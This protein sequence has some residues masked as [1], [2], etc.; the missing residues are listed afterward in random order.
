MP[1]HFDCPGSRS[2]TAEYH[3]ELSLI[4]VLNR[5]HLLADLCK[6]VRPP[7]FEL[8]FGDLRLCRKDLILRINRQGFKHYADVICRGFLPIHA[9]SPDGF[10]KRGAVYQCIQDYCSRFHV[11]APVKEVIADCFCQ[12]AQY[13]QFYRVVITFRQAFKD[14]LF[15][16]IRQ[17]ENIIYFAVDTVDFSITGDVISAVPVPSS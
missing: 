1:R 5:R 8:R 10:N 3:F 9:A 16:R 12:F 15:G 6:N 2:L 11:Y 13:R 14:Y 7:S 17:R 4:A